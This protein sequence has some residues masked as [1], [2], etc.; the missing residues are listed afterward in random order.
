M[1]LDSKNNLAGQISAHGSPATGASPEAPILLVPYMWIGDFVRCHTVVRLLNQRFPGRPVDVLGTRMV[2]P[3]A[4]Y[5]PGVRKAVVADLPRKRLAL[6]EHQALAARLKAEGYGDALIMPRTWKS[7]LAPFLAGIVRRTGFFGEARIGLL[8]D[9]RSG[10][11]ALPRMIDRC[12]ALAM[13]KGENAPADLPLPQ[14]VV[15]MNEIAS[16]KHRNGIAD[17]PRPAVA[18]APGAVGPSKRWTTEGFAELAK[19]LTAAG[20]QVWV[21]GGPDEGALANEI[22]GPEQANVRNMTGPDLRNAILA[23][24]A[25]DV[26]VSNDSGL[27]HVAAAIGTPA[28]GIF[29]PTSPWHW[30]PLNPLAAVVETTTDVSC[31]PCHKPTCRMGHH[32]CM[33]DIAAD[34]IVALT[35]QALR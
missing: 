7:A 30:A 11:R 5:M 17:D 19:R 24:A 23:L 3:L 31:R 2:S 14:L 4:D 25:A 6:T 35:M 12:A 9:L 18:L 16:W 22:A 32:L 1:N 13:P 21:L 26:A 20:I 29:G 8:N 27:L 15:P 33:R 34:R 10:E 28:I